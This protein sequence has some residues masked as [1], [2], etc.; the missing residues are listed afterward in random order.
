MRTN[1]SSSV[2]TPP[3]RVQAS[4]RPSP[5][6]GIESHEAS[7][8]AF[9]VPE[10]GAFGWPETQWVGVRQVDEPNGVIGDVDCRF[11]AAGSVKPL[12]YSE[13][14]VRLRSPV[15]PLNLMGGSSVSCNGS[16]Y[17]KLV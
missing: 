8:S 17:V 15:T 10:Q 1:I 4:H 14:Y 9:E 3:L 12:S 13:Q 5:L 6:P 2:V 16:L 11:T 7:R